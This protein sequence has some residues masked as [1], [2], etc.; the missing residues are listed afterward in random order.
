MTL[1]DCLAYQKSEY[2]KQ[3]STRGKESLRM[4]IKMKQALPNKRY[5]TAVKYWTP[6][7]WS[8][9][10]RQNA[11]NQRMYFGEGS[12]YKF[13]R[14]EK[15]PTPKLLSLLTWGMDPEKYESGRRGYLLRR[16]LT[17]S[18]SR[19]AAIDK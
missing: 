8:W 1:A 16:L 11:F 12:L 4:V 6:S 17:E 19:K 7:M 3:G 10:R 15:K 13:I 9:A 2:F 18:K 5:E 14:D